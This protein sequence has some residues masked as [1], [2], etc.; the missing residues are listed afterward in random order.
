MPHTPTVGIL[1]AV[2]LP[3]DPIY[4]VRHSDPGWAAGCGS[5]SWLLHSHNLLLLD[6]EDIS[7]SIMSGVGVAHI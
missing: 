2:S 1:P 7:H 5:E 3:A 4:I 6:A